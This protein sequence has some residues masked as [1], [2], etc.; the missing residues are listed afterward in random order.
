MHL[1]AWSCVFP[2]QEWSAWTRR[3]VPDVATVP[4]ASLAMARAASRA[5]PAPITCAIRKSLLHP[6]IPTI[7]TYMYIKSCACA[8][9]ARKINAACGAFNGVKGVAIASML[10]VFVMLRQRGLEKRRHPKGLSPSWLC[11]Y[12]HLALMAIWCCLWFDDLVKQP[13]SASLTSWP[14]AS[15]CIHIHISICDW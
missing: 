12:L 15:I 14:E 6:Y 7:Y 8:L 1:K 4:L 9:R 5:L 11:N 13:S 3:P 2:P 10:I